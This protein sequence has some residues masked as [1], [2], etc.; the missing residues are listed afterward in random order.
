[1]IAEIDGSNIQSE[2]DFHKE[3]AGA[4]SL[5]PY[6]GRNLNALWDVLSCDVER[7]VT[8]VWKN[9]DASRKSMPADF[10]KITDLL[11]DIEKED[12][13]YDVSARFSFIAD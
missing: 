10:E 3:I 2:A 5:G 12:A 1:M 13:A 8:L 6:Y 9:A 7:P 4:L 11:R